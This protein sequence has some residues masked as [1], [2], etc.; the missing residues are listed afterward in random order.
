MIRTTLHTEFHP[1][2]GELLGG[3]RGNATLDC[4]GLVIRKLRLE[5]TS[6]RV[7]PDSFPVLD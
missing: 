7:V 5:D 1:G 4:Q 6:V 3:A 2:E